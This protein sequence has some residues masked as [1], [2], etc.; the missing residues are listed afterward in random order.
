MTRKRG[1]PASAIRGLA[2]A[3]KMG[4]KITKQRGYDSQEWL[5]KECC[6]D[7]TIRKVCPMVSTYMNHVKKNKIPMSDY[8]KSFKDGGLA[9]AYKHLSINSKE[10]NGI[11]VAVSFPSLPA[12]RYGQA[13]LQ[14]CGSAKQTEFPIEINPKR[15]ACDQVHT[16]IHE[17]VHA[18]QA[19]KKRLQ[20][21]VW[22]SDRQCHVRWDG[23]KF[24][25]MVPGK[26]AVT[27]DDGTRV[28]YKD[29]PW[30]R[31]ARGFADVVYNDFRKLYP[32]RCP[33]PSLDASDHPARLKK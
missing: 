7:D 33:A 31:E 26:E 9:G 10:C 24:G 1:S 19:A 6:I 8:R 3:S 12:H 4:V 16:L 30:E 5:W 21:R 23:Q 20:R 11:D 13:Y 2:S 17:L 18:N 27:L 15:D 32:Q 22:K 25:A 28:N 29:L 14:T